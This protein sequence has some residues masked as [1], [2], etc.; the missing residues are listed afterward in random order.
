MDDEGMY[1]CLV[2]TAQHQAQHN[3]QLLVAGEEG[4]SLGVTEVPCSQ[5]LKLHSAPLL[6]CTQ[7][8][9]SQAACGWMALMLPANSY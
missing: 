2:S 8:T 6:C 4:K 9:L 5:A 3:I 1:I 7:H